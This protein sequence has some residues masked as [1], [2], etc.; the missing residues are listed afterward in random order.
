M[1]NFWIA[2]ISRMRNL[3]RRIFRKASARDKLIQQ[4]V[5]RSKKVR[6]MMILLEKQERKVIKAKQEVAQLIHEYRKTI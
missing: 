2:A 1:V 4:I 5:K 6:R 3:F